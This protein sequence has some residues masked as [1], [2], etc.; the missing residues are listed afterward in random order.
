MEDDFIHVT[1]VEEL[2]AFHALHHSL[3]VLTR[4]VL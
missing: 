4:Q 1:C 2:A 3:Q